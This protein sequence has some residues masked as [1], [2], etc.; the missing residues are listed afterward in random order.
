VVVALGALNLL[1]EKQP[2]RARGKGNRIELEVGEDVATRSGLRQSLAWVAF[3]LGDL[4]EAAEHA[5][6]SLQD[7]EGIDD[8]GVKADSLATLGFLGFVCGTAGVD[9]LTEA[10]ALQDQMMAHGSWTEASVYTTPRSVLGLE[11]MWSGRLGEAREVFERELWRICENA[12][13]GQGG[14]TWIH[15]FGVTSMAA[16]DCCVPAQYPSARRV[17]RGD[18]MFCE[19]S[20]QFWDYPGQVLRS[21]SVESEPT[22]LYRELYAVAD[23]AFRSISKVVKKGSPASALVEASGVIEKAGFTTCDDLVH[24]FVGG[25]VLHLEYDPG[26]GPGLAGRDVVPAGSQPAARRQKPR[27]DGRSGA[28]YPDR[29]LGRYD[30]SGA[31]ARRSDSAL[32]SR[33]PV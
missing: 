24:G 9:R 16:P 15:Y 5:R 13:A 19:I 12:Y 25:R 28:A 22:A 31:W 18:V 33:R 20:A 3:Y 2:R 8:L 17:R 21:F 32:R 10:I 4:G 29:R 7:A 1:A 27:G 30:G 14:T 6:R 23:E 11:L 26:S